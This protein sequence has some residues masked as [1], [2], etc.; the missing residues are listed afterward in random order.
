MA[1]SPIDICNMALANIG[2]GS[3]QSFNSPT[4]AS[5]ICKQRYDET[6]REALSAT[7]WNFASLWTLGLA[8]AIDPKPPWS[9]VYAYPAGALKVFEILKENG[10]TTDIPFEVT[11]RP[12]A[13]GM[14]IHCNQAAPTFIYAK[15]IDD[16]TFFT[17]EFTNAMAWLLASKIAMTITKSDKLQT[18]AYKMW[19]GLSSQAITASANEGKPDADI[20]AGYQE[21]R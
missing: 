17:S 4:A 7:L 20:T 1:S 6:R 5:R 3:I 12:D 9:Y 15:D 8:V 19:V 11:A 16:V 21:A 10:E 14:L 18:N 13:A 2:Q